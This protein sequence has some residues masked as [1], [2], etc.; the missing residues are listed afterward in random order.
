MTYIAE[1]LSSGRW[2]VRPEATLGTCGWKD[3]K[4]WTAWIGSARNEQ[5]AINKARRNHEHR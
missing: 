2:C 1:R 4:P 3:G 5:D